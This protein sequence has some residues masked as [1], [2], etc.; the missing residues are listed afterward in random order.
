MALTIDRQRA[1]EIARLLE[2]RMGEQPG[3][4]VHA[5]FD[6]IVDGD[7]IEQILVR[8]DWEGSTQAVVALKGGALKLSDASLQAMEFPR[9]AD[10]V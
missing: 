3:T 9:P 1:S 10:G 8:L 5:D 7:R 6:Y 4:H 2:A